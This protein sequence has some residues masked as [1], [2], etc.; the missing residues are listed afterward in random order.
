MFCANM[1]VFYKSCD[2]FAGGHEPEPTGGDAGTGTARPAAGASRAGRGEVPEPAA[3][4]GQ[5]DGRHPAPR[6]EPPASRSRNVQGKPQ[7]IMA[8]I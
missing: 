6:H 2:I 3:E 5:R 8:V 1:T 7:Y 4:Q